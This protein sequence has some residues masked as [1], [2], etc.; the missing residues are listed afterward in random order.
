[1]CIYI[2]IFKKK[3]NY[4]KHLIS[5]LPP[6]FFNPNFPANALKGGVTTAS[7]AV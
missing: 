2:Y 6:P 7:L 3:K 1:M 5:K 4:I